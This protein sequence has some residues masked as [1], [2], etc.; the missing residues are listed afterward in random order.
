MS[1]SYTQN[2]TV[3]GAQTATIVNAISGTA[4][5]PFTVSTAENN[6]TSVNWLQ[7]NV[8][9][10][11]PVS[12]PY[13]NP[14]L[15]VSV[16]PGSLAPNT[17]TGTVTISPTGGSPVII[18]VTLTVVS[19]AVVTATCSGTG[20]TG[21]TTLNLTYLVGGT[22]PTA[23]IQVSGGGSSAAFTAS[24]ASS[25]GWLQVTPT[26]GTTP[27][28]GTFNLTASIV[29]SVLSSLLPS[30]SPYSGTITVTGTSPATG[31]T[32][33]NVTLTVTA[34]LPVI[35]GI[36]NAASGATGSI[37]VGEIISIFGTPANP[38]GPATSVQLN[39][40]TCPGNCTL[41]PTTLGNS[42]VQVKFVPGEVSAPLLFVNEGQINA[43]VPYGVAGI[44]GLSVEVLYLGQTS[45]AFP[46]ALAPTAPGLFTSNSSGTGQAAAEQ[47]DTL[48]N[49]S[50]NVAATPAKAGWTL[51]LY[52]T[53]EGQVSPQVASGAVTVY[54][55]LSNPPV[56]VP[57]A[58]APHVLIGG[59]PAT[60]SFY[61]E[62][63]GL[64]SGVLQINVVV[65]AGAG[66]G[67]VPISVSLGTASSQAGVT[68]ALQ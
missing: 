64:V 47:Y 4:S 55:A 25:A 19:N 32:I 49:F 40:T 60:V 43:V 22:S 33:I 28:S 41:V 66:T 45:N 37:A 16:A 59:Q 63:P 52:M 30:G 13:N 27:N 2:Q 1:F 11:T 62:A 54:N 23:T 5:I 46:V 50:Y 24:A 53:G 34:P 20:C 56:P 51:V 48:G 14:G 58:G 31:T 15:S 36:T 6:G 35:T 17:Y 8:A 26:T 57:V 18:N 10:N 29:P 61:G 44:A 67:A 42:G 9:S 68:V 12:T 38:I 7:T 39:S 65:P 3:P 21:S